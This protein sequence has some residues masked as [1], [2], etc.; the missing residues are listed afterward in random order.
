M[1]MKGFALGVLSILFLVIVTPCVD[2]QSPQ[3]Y[4]DYLSEADR[5]RSALS[6]FRDAR[7]AYLKYKTLTSETAAQEK[8]KTFMFRRND[9]IVAYLKYLREQVSAASGIQGSTRDRLLA[10]IDKNLKEV[11]SNSGLTQTTNTL[12]QLLEPGKDF[13]TRYPDVRKTM[14]ESALSLSVGAASVLVGQTRTA[15]D[16]LD[17]TITENQSAFSTQK[18]AALVHWLN[19]IKDSATA[20][21]T[22]LKT[23][24]KAIDIMDT[25]ADKRNFDETVKTVSDAVSAVKTSLQT[26]GKQIDELTRII[27][28]E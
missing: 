28:N 12:S 7:S 10:R 3:T 1:R 8:T 13:E 26:T 16:V 14:M 15:A 5:Y 23:A 27:A 9:V 21:E 24:N 18:K 22:S 2:A 11:T 4:T 19:T 25:S 17:A 20:N 6:E